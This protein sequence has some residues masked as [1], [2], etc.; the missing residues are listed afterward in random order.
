MQEKVIE[1]TDSDGKITEITTIKTPDQ[2]NSI[3]LAQNAKGEKSWEIKIYA[4]DPKDADNLLREYR[5]IAES[6]A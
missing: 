3:K 5:R 1:K 2:Q 4:D 6:Q